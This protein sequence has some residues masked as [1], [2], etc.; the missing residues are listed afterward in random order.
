M[1]KKVLENL[2]EDI[3][4]ELKIWDDC[5]NKDLEFYVEFSDVAHNIYLT[6]QARLQEVLLR[7]DKKDEQKFA[8]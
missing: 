4:D 5:N 1:E 7:L 3:K 2:L 6:A 8:N